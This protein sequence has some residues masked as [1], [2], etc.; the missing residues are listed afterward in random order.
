MTTYTQIPAKRLAVGDRY[1]PFDARE[2][3]EENGH[4]SRTILR[5]DFTGRGDYSTIVE[6]DGCDWTERFEP[7]EPV[8]LVTEGGSDR[9]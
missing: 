9:G 7:D 4:W 6:I 1:V 5:H 3:S 2:D 8:W